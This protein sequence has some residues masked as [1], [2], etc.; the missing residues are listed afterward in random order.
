MIEVI[1]IAFALVGVVALATLVLFLFSSVG[2]CVENMYIKSAVA[3]IGSKEFLTHVAVTSGGEVIS[4]DQDQCEIFTDNKQWFERLT[5]DVKTAQ[6][7]IS[8]STYIWEE[9][10]ASV[11]FFKALIDAVNRGVEV[12]LLIDSFGSSM[13]K[14]LIERLKSSGIIVKHFRPFA[15]GKLS[16]YFSRNHRRSYIFD[17]TVAYIGGASVSEKWFRNHGKKFTPY[18]DVMYRMKGQAVFQASIAFGELWTA[19][20][21]EVLQ[22]PSSDLNTE[23][24]QL[25]ALFLN[26]SPRVDVHPYTYLLWYSCMAAKEKIIICSPYVVPG[27]AMAKLLIQKARSGVS[28][29]IITQGTKEI[30]FVSRTGQ[31]YYES[32]LEAGIQIYE[33]R[34][35]AHLHTK[36]TVIDD[37]WTIIGS[38]NFDIRSQRINH[39][40]VLG[41]SDQPFAARNSHI[42]AGY[43]ENARNIELERWRRR[44][45]SR[46]ILEKML[47]SLSEQM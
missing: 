20:S 11:T 12:R 27:E 46:K 9:D 14:E 21:G 42:A 19:A 37:L 47:T 10:E 43:I 40:S 38:A 35:P 15:F 44:P 32:F 41:V 5:Q 26:H 28:I 25:N 23:A 17:G 36:L 16:F 18:E 39:E 31:S 2:K 24:N 3:S 1:T 22:L 29:Q 8:I 33:Y 4:F 13:K 7:Y 6:V 34:G 45:Y 30:W